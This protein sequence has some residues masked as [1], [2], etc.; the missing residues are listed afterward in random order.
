MRSSALAFLLNPAAP[1][2]QSNIFLND[3]LR[4]VG[5]STTID[6]YENCEVIPEYYIRENGR[7]ID[8][9]LRFSNPEFAIG[10]EN[11]PWFDDPKW[12]S[13]LENQVR[14]YCDHL[15]AR[16]PG[17]WFFVYLSGAGL[18][19]PGYSIPVDRW[20]NYEAS[21]SV[22]RMSYRTLVNPRSRSL[23][24]W[25]G[26]CV[27]ACEAESVTR[28]LRDFLGY[29]ARMGGSGRQSM[30][31]SE[32]E[33][34]SFILS[35]ANRLIIAQDLKRVMGEIP[36]ILIGAFLRHLAELIRQELEEPEWIVGFANSDDPD[37]MGPQAGLFSSLA[38]CA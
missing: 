29:V 35:D 8:I 27:N 10:M 6:R 2:G 37:L 11:K 18:E 22:T 23:A 36:K 32:Q 15:D 4:V 9:L 38:W 28:F 13:D 30:T 33:I 14:D 5:I 20:K 3:F 26:N 7:F 12:P 16:Y 31:I 21:G 1:H 19:P 24:E 17:R 34:A 25:L